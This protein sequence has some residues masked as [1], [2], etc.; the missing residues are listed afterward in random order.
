MNP[1]IAII[2]EGKG[3]YSSADFVSV[4]I[5]NDMQSALDFQIENTLG[6]KHWKKVELVTEGQSIETGVE[7]S[8]F[9]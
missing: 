2:L 3:Y 4:K 9:V 8:D 6:G 7:P 5:F 1:I